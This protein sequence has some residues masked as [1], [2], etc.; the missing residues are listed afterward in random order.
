MQWLWTEILAGR[1]LRE[2]QCT[3]EEE[4]WYVNVLDSE[5]WEGVYRGCTVEVAVF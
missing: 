5:H 2:G 4:G 1:A 3:L